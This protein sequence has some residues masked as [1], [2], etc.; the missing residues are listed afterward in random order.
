MNEEKKDQPKQKKEAEAKE[1][2]TKKSEIKKIEEKKPAV[3]SLPMVPDD[4]EIIA[5]EMQEMFEEDEVKHQHGGTEPER[6]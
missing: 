5:N 4:S 3:F 1:E 2:K 6:D